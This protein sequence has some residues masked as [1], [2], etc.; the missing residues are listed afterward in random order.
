LRGTC[1]RGGGCGSGI[2]RLRIRS[3]HAGSA[4]GCA[5]RSGGALCAGANTAPRGLAGCACSRSSACT[6]ARLGISPAAAQQQRSCQKNRSP[7]CFTF[8]FSESKWSLLIRWVDDHDK[9]PCGPWKSRASEFTFQPAVLSPA[10][11]HPPAAEKRAALSNGAAQ[12]Q[13]VAGN[14]VS[15]E[16]F[17][18]CRLGCVF[19]GD[20]GAVETS[21]R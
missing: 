15:I 14:H 3:T 11:A 17:G 16:L 10:G 12:W 18:V 13:L 21:I 5:V 4:V 20:R 2:V 6:G 9:M 1:A 19:A 7:H 8:R